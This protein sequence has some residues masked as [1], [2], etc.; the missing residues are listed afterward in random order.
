[1]T[2]QAIVEIVAALTFIGGMLAGLSLWVLRS[3][4]SRE[5]TPTLQTLATEC[6]GL[7]AA[8][9]DAKEMTAQERKEAHQIIGD[10][11]KIVANLDTR[12]TVIERSGAPPR[13]SGR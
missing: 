7:A 3:I 2:P 5:V 12:V 11:S 4:L 9:R 8:F 1:M 6:K 10:L 13:H